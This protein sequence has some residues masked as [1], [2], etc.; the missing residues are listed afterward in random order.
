MEPIKPRWFISPMQ[1]LIFIK[2]LEGD[3]RELVLFQKDISKEFYTELAGRDSIVLW[4]FGGT[5]TGKSS[6]TLELSLIKDPDMSP[7]RVAFTNSEIDA[8]LKESAPGDGII[9]DETVKDFGEGS[10]QLLSKLQDATETL[11]KRR[12]SFY[13]LSPVIKGIPFIHYYLEILQTSVNL[14]EKAIKREIRKGLKF[15][16]FK[17]GVWSP[18]NTPLGYLTLKTKVNNLLYQGYEARKNKFIPLMASGDRV[19]GLD[20]GMEAQRFL[21][22]IDVNTYPRKGERLNFIKMNS[23]YTGGQCK[24][25]HTEVERLIRLG[26]DY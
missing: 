13:L 14:E 15:I 10:Q 9:R 26:D 3:P 7:D 2:R 22:L 17:V 21:N 24:S 1:E 8:I 6:F 12:N 11:R 16:E 19:S 20:I 23:N 5:G 18:D 25:I 4:I